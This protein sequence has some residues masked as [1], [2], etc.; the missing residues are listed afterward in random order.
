MLAG[1]HFATNA[2]HVKEQL[3]IMAG[4]VHVCTGRTTVQL[5]IAMFI[6]NILVVYLAFLQWCPVC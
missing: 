2:R 1:L 6:A 5:G 4:D 3:E